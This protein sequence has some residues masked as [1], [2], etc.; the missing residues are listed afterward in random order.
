MLSSLSCLM[1]VVKELTK[2]HTKQ[3]VTGKRSAPLALSCQR[4]QRFHERRQSSTFHASV[5]MPPEIKSSFLSLLHVLKM[6]SQ[7]FSL[8]IGVGQKQNYVGGRATRICQL[9]KISQK[10]GKFQGF[11]T[12]IC[13]CFH[14]EKGGI[15]KGGGLGEGERETGG[16]IKL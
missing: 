8:L 3:K 14:S 1:T 12:L 15:S 10:S 2:V 6:P 13:Y 5:K 9:K 7:A 4:G 11:M 16:L